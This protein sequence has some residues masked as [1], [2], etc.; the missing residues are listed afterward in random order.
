[1]FFNRCVHSNILTNEQF[2][3]HTK[4]GLGPVQYAFLKEVVSKVQF[5]GKINSFTGIDD[6]TRSHNSRQL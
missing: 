1:M 6:S 5:F 2:K 3:R 4:S